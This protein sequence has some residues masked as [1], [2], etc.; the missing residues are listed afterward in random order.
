MALSYSSASGAGELGVGWSLSGQ[1]SLH[2]C[3]HSLALDGDI[4]GVRVDDEDALCLDGARL[5]LA[6]GEPF[7][8]GAVYRPRVDDLTRV[9]VIPGSEDGELICAGGY[10]FE[11]DHPDGTRTIYGCTRDATVFTPQGPL[12]WSRARVRDRPART[13]PHP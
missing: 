10:G 5:M 12:A 3:P 2:R 13:P 8:L 6:E 7:S 4:R 11:L 9:R 1:S